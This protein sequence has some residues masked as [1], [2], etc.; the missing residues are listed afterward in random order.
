MTEE[1]A[2][3][4]TIRE[5]PTDDL[6]RQVYADWLDDQ[7]HPGADYLRT[8]LA[9]FHAS[10]DEVPRLRRQLLA[11]IPGLPTPWRDR[12]EQ[13]ELLL[14]P[15]VPFPL[16]WYFEGD[17]APR[18]YRSLPNLDSA[19]LS[20]EMP[21]LSG[22]GA[23]NRVDQESHEREELAALEILNERSE[24]LG[25]LLPPGFEALAR[26]FRRR[27]AICPRSSS[28]EVCLHDSVIEDFAQFGDGYLILFFGDMNYGNPHQLS[29]A[30]YLIPGV[31][32]HCVVVYELAGRSDN[33]VPESPEDIFYCAPSFP[34]FFYRWWLKWRSGA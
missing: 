12:F 4:A 27:S 13:P 2:L 8:E 9:L 1:D 10:G 6:P 15:P 32:W 16:G 21:W 28:C 19:M 7:G 34:A 5:A 30:L 29:W 24:R 25:L 22:E 33:L 26:D 31:P 18:P 11:I 17:Q 3:I 20:P 23:R 14:A